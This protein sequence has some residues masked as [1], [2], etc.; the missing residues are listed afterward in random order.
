MS[1]MLAHAWL[2]QETPL[3]PLNALYEQ[4]ILVHVLV[5]LDQ[6]EPMMPT[7]DLDGVELFEAVVGNVPALCR[8]II[9]DIVTK[10]ADVPQCV[11]EAYV[12]HGILAIPEHWIFS[13]ATGLVADLLPDWAE[14]E[15]L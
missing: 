1:T 11:R 5:D 12:L 8:Q 3:A 15:T 7:L 6:D 10:N 9:T 14:G 2:Y 13:L 4:G